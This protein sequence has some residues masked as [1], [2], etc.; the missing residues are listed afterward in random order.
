M[1][2]LVATDKVLAFTSDS[3]DEHEAILHPG[4]IVTLLETGARSK[5]I[6]ETGQELFVPKIDSEKEIPNTR[7]VLEYPGTFT[8]P[9]PVK[10]SELY[11]FVR[12]N[13]DNIGRVRI[14]MNRPSESIDK[15]VYPRQLAFS[16]A[17]KL[18]TALAEEF[19]FPRD[20]VLIQYTD[21]ENYEN[22]SGGN[23]GIVIFYQN[24]TD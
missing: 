8:I 24:I 14:L 6:T 12:E 20:D 15:S 3:A 22:I 23:F 19:G 4:E 5:I 1:I 16:R 21:G 17:L 10:F 18:R 9:T 7:I 2:E 13:F 11:L